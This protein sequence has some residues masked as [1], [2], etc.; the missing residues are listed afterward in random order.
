MIEKTLHKLAERVLSL[1]EAS[2]T[3]L[4]EK[5]KARTEHFEVSKDWEKSIIIFFMI[6]AVRAKNRL[7]NEQILKMQNLPAT[8]ENVENANRPLQGK[9]NLR[10]IK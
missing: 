6:N 3:A 9:P 5:Y 8:P 1:D 2:L 4:W 7:F 10:R